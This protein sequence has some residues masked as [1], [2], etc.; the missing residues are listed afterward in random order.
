[1]D[2]AA[3]A[4][5]RVHARYGLDLTRQMPGES[6][7]AFGARYS[8]AAP[9][10]TASSRRTSQLGCALLVANPTAG[11]GGRGGWRAQVAERLAADGVEV[12][13][14]PT[15][16]LEDARLAACE[17]AGEVDAVV[18]MGGDG[19][20]GACAAGLADAG[21]ESPV[22]RASGR[23]WR[24]CRPVGGTTPPAA[25]ACLPATRWPRPGCCG[26]CGGGPD[27]ATVAGR[28]YVNVAGAG[29]DSE[30]NR[31]A[32]QRLGWAGN[33]PRYIGAVL[34]QLVVGRP[35]GS[36]WSW[37]AASWPSGA[38]WWRWPTAPA[39]AAACGSPPGQP[40]RRPARRGRDRRHRQ[41]RVPA[42]L[43]QGVLRPPRRAPAVAVHRAA[44]V[45]LEADR[46]L[47]VYADGEPAGTLP[48]TFEVRPAAI[49][50][51]A[52]DPAPGSR[53]ATDLGLPSLSVTWENA[54]ST[55][56]PVGRPHRGR[57]GCA[58]PVS[59]PWLCWWPWW[60]RSCPRPGGRRPTGAPAC[61]PV[62]TPV[63]LAGQ[64]PTAE[65]VIGFPLGERDVTVA[66]SDAYLQAVAEASLGG[67][68]HRRHL[69]AGPAPALRHRRP[70]R[71]RHPGRPGP[72][73]PPDRPAARPPHPG[74]GGRPPGQDHP[75]HPL[76]G[77]QRPRRRG[78]RHRRRP[79][80][81][82]RA[83]R[84]PRL[85]RRP[86]PRQ[87]HR[88]PAA[89]PEPRRPRGRHPPQRLRLRPEPRLVRPHPARDRRQ[90]PAAAPLPAGAVHR[91]PRDE[92]QT[93]FFPPNADPIYHEITD[94]SVDW[95]NNLYGAAM[96]DEFTRQGIP[97]F[98]RDVYDLFYMGYGD[99]VPP[100]G[101]SPPA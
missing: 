95:I 13:R 65:Q 46:P 48:A 7:E 79:A 23:R 92:P 30:V 16:S 52:A 27:L 2:A 45:E 53:Q 82:V 75:G 34:A 87:R 17:A 3:G 33:R 91:R 49:T 94:E 29:F 5:A 38:G 14:H 20:V 47:A 88:G 97:F 9:T 41:A 31:V 6:S 74:Q 44:R 99:T 57:S 62:R 42:D 76:G 18:A 72:H 81:P 1:M 90:A 56:L 43:P 35:P 24:W 89:D 63:E 54:R 93:F 32:N 71:Q 84:P 73:P 10:A 25:W 59:S 40:G 28:A 64:V 4:L 67:G 55:R 83:G 77:R 98:N 8:G 36:G 66:E 85:R 86:D 21:P 37:T 12:A 96:A 100:P 80:G 11:G 22:G 60:P 68:R 101:S 69:L 51:L 58:V 78:E 61:D 15:R 26:G 50:V 39:T 19:T 70:P